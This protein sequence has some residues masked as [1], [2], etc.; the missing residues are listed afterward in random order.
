MAFTLEGNTDACTVVSLTA[1]DP[2]KVAKMLARG[3]Y[4]EMR[5]CG[6]TPNQVIHAAGEII[7]ELT[8]SLNRHKKR[9]GS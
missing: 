8:G 9:L 5:H 2:D 1:H 3:F 7:S 6:F 4:R